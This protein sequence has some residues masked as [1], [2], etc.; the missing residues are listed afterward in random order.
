[1]APLY[2]S[3]TF[4]VLP[5][6]LSGDTDEC[7]GCHAGRRVIPLPEGDSKTGSRQRQSGYRAFRE[8][9]SGWIREASMPV[10][11]PPL[12][13]PSLSVPCPG[14][15]LVRA[16][17]TQV[18]AGVEFRAQRTGLGATH[19]LG[20]RRWP[21]GNA[22]PIDL[23]LIVDHGCRPGHDTIACVMGGRPKC[24]DSTGVI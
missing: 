17:P 12:A 19:D 24:P 1:M 8:I 3:C 6:P 10:D 15:R 23:Y 9:R 11:S 20:V 5:Y 18:G 13:V 16:W 4:S 2:L 7:S 14:L 22:A 21:R